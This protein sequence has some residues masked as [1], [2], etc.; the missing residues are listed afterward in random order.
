MTK[1]PASTG[2]AFYRGRSSPPRLLYGFPN[3]LKKAPGV[4]VGSRYFCRARDAGF[5]ELQLISFDFPT[6]PAATQQQRHRL[7][8]WHKTLL[9]IVVRR[10]EQHRNHRG[11]VH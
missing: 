2:G 7:I 5:E 11:L 4:E 9:P 8:E 6:A 10:V 1:G 3:Q